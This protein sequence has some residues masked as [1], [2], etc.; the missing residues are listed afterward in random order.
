MELPFTKTE[1]LNILCFHIG[2]GIDEKKS[3][4]YFQGS[5]AFCWENTTQ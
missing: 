4:L 3:Y 5:N 2:C 1:K